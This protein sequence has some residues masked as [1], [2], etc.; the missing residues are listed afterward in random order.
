MAWMTPNTGDRSHQSITQRNA[1]N[2]ARGSR[3]G[4]SQ[5]MAVY[6]IALLVLLGTVSHA[7]VGAVL[8][9]P[10]QTFLDNSGNVVANGSLTVQ[11]CG[12]TTPLTVYSDSTLS[13][14]LPDPVTLNSAGRPQTGAGVETAVYLTAVCHK[15]ILKNSAGTTLWTQDNVYPQNYLGSGTAS[16]LTY[17]RGD[18]AWASLFALTPEDYS[19]VGDGVTNDTTA[20][21][22]FI[23]AV[24]ASTHKVGILGCKTYLINAALPTINTTGV[25]LIGCGAASSHDVGTL[26]GVGVTVIKWDAAAAGAAMLTIQPDTGASAQ[27]LD[28]IRIEGITFDASADATYGLVINSVF[29]SFFDVSVYN[30]VTDGMKLGVVATLGEARD[31]QRNVFRYTSRQIEAP[32]GVGLRLTGDATANVSMNIFERID[33]AHAN[34]EAISLDGS[35]NN[36]WQSVR[37]L[38]SGTATNSIIFRGSDASA[39]QI[40]AN[41]EFWH[42][43]VNQ[44]VIA[45]GTSSYTYPAANIRIHALDKGNGSPDPTIETGASLYWS[46][47]TTPIYDGVWQTY[48]PTIAASAGTFTTVSAT[49]RYQYKPNGIQLEITVVITTIGTASGYWTATLPVTSK[50]NPHGSALAAI[51]IQSTGAVGGGYVG[52]AATTVVV[53]AADGSFF[54]TTGRTVIVTGFYA[55]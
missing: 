17:L 3:S 10:R 55:T 32:A 16:R 30:A 9:L 7:Q 22:N 40:S 31:L 48:T 8:P 39:T 49:G 34:A 20:L 24:E 26:G 35:D 50:N 38:E 36:T 11:Q 1:P 54:G 14:G 51:E 6:A 44:A 41:E 25:K 4:R 52:P 28:G 43:T 37:C 53:R 27:R 15:F 19:A 46:N 29:N 2:A 23:T 21:S 47:Q 5:R 18:Y 42:V 13:T 45:K 33:V 12:T